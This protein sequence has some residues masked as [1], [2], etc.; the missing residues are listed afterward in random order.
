MALPAQG[1]YPTDPAEQDSSLNPYSGGTD[2][3]RGWKF[4]AAAGALVIVGMTMGIIGVQA[5]GG[6][7]K[8]DPSTSSYL[9]VIEEDFGTVFAR[10]TAAKAQVMKRQLDILSARYD[11]SDRPASDV[12][13]SRG[14]AVQ[15][16]VRVKLLGGSTWEALVRMT[17]DEL[18]DK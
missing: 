14:K 5:Q 3:R 11:L 8:A 10:M 9:P 15:V 13:M 4:I 12:T 2:M 16:G 6:P 1:R 7:P 17:P 18:R